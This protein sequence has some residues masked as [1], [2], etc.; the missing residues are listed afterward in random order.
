MAGVLA[1]IAFSAAGTFAILKL[2]AMF[3]PVRATARDEGLGLD[4]TQHG[5]E[6]YSRGEGAILV[7]PDAGPARI[8][9]VAPPARLETEP[10]TG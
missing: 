4:V 7:L 9:P 1:T 5:E 2:L 3:G 6:A 8:L 10:G